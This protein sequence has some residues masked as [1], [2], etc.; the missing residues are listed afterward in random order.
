[1][2]FSF[3]DLTKRGET[4]YSIRKKVE[5]GELIKLQRG[6]YSDDPNELGGEAYYCKKYPDAILTG[7]SAFY[8]YDLTDG[9]PDYYYLTTPRNAIP[10]NDPFVKQSYQNTDTINIGV[11][12]METDSGPVRIYDLE[13]TLIELVR[14]RTKYPADLYY[15]V[16]SSFRTRKDELDLTKVYDY[17]AAFKNGKNLFQKIKEAMV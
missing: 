10:I 15:E 16:L 2:I 13:R 14:L 6:F 1:M 8:L 12:T 5:N 11:A 9:A 17:L 4:Q 3:G 7:Y